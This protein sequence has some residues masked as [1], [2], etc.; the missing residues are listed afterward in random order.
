MT[1]LE[2]VCAVCWMDLGD[3]EEVV[4]MLNCKH[5]F[6]RICVDGWGATQLREKRETTCPTCRT[7]F[8]IVAPPSPVKILTPVIALLP[9]S[10][11]LAHQHRTPQVAPLRLPGNSTDRGGGGVTCTQQILLFV[12]NMRGKLTR[13]G[14]LNH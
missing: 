14:I 6:C 12:S 1:E 2:N 11:P 8:V 13:P 4:T 7:P 9:V 5:T 3:V 10:P